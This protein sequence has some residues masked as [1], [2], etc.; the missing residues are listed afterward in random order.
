MLSPILS[1]YIR[2]D[3]AS[4]VE[5]ENWDFFQKLIRRISRIDV[6]ILIVMPI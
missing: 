5:D 4:G 3:V 6:K 1:L 2:D